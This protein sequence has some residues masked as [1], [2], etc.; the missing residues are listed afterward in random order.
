[1]RKYPVLAALVRVCTQNYQIPDTNVIIEKGTEV[2]IPLSG[3]HRDNMYFP[4]PDQF[5][6]DRFKEEISS[7]NRFTYLP[8]GE[9][10]RNCIG[11]LNG[12]K[13]KSYEIF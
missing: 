6:P 3:I 13:L 9:G 11:K 7:F 12:L 5:N 8:F 2:M 1:M 4:D 10:P